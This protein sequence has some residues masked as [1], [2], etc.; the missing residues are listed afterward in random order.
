MILVGCLLLA[1][2]LYAI[3]CAVTKLHI[4]CI[5]HEITG[6]KCPGC[7]VTTMCMCLLR[8]DFKGA[9][10]ANTAI[11]ILLPFLAYLAVVSAFRYVKT[12]AAK[13]YPAENILAV[14]ACVFLVVFGILRNI[15]AITVFN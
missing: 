14:I 13:L 15:P 1:G 5:F 9:W 2:I 8:L 4:P 11:M 7:G 6:L 12:G 3:F 10:Q